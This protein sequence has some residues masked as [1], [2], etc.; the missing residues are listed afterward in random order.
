MSQTVQQVLP[1]VISIL[2]IVAIALLQAHS[3]TVAAVTATMPL[4][5]PLAL[6]IVYAANRADRSAITGFTESLL[7]GV[8][9]TLVFTVALWLAARAGL[10][11]GPML[12]SGYV[13]W[14]LTLGL[15]AALR[16]LL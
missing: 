4:T 13:A 14:A 8:I 3:K 16:A 15:H 10:R 12:L 9:A 2:V 11:L 6:W 7:V 5:I 1:V